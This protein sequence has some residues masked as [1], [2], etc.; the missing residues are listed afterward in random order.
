MFTR[1][2]VE[3]IPKWLNE[4]S[5]ISRLNF[6]IFLCD[7]FL[8][9]KIRF[10]F[11]R[12]F[13]NVLHFLLLIKFEIMWRLFFFG[14]LVFLCFYEIEKNGGILSDFYMGDFNLKIWKIIK[15]ECYVSG[16]MLGESYRVFSRYV[17]MKIIWGD[18][19]VTCYTLLVKF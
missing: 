17:M 3:A 13:W 7:F 16:K 2:Y 12:F 6:S 1:F 9:K 11:L 14:F 5:I 15:L 10:S 18:L 19:V 8:C 4:H